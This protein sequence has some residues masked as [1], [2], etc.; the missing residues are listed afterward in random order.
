V[1]RTSEQEEEIKYMNVDDD[2]AEEA[3]EVYDGK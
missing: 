1:S 2:V 3:E